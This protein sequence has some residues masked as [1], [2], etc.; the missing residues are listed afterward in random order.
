M[1]S[2]NKEFKAA[3]YKTFDSNEMVSVTTSLNDLSEGN[4]RYVL[5]VDVNDEKNYDKLKP[6]LNEFKAL[7]EKNS[8]SF[9]V[10][11]HDSDP[12][13][14][15]MKDLQQFNFH[16]E[17]TTLKKTIV[18]K[19]DIMTKFIFITDDLNNMG[20]CKWLQSLMKNDYVLT[21]IFA[22][23]NN[24]KGTSVV[25]D[26][27]NL[28]NYSSVVVFFVKD[29]PG[30]MLYANAILSDNKIVVGFAKVGHTKL[31]LYNNHTSS[32][33]LYDSKGIKQVEITARN[34]TQTIECKRDN[35]MESST[36]SYASANSM[37]KLMLE[38]YKDGKTP[39]PNL[40][41]IYSK[42]LET[43]G[44]TFGLSIR[45]IKMYKAL[46]DKPENCD[47]VFIYNLFQLM[48]SL[49]YIDQTGGEISIVMND[50][51][52][53]DVTNLNDIVEA[54]KNARSK[55]TTEELKSND[56]VTTD[57]SVITTDDSVITIV[58]DSS[59]TDAIVGTFCLIPTIF[60]EGGY[61]TYRGIYRVRANEKKIASANM[62]NTFIVLDVSGSMQDYF[63]K[64][65]NMITYTI[66]SLGEN[67]KLTVILFST[68]FHTL[69]DML[70]GSQANKEKMLEA[71]KNSETIPELWGGWTN[72]YDTITECIRLITDYKTKNDDTWSFVLLTDGEPNRG[73]ITT[74]DGA[75]AILKDLVNLPKIVPYLCTY[76]NGIGYAMLRDALPDNKKDHYMHFND[77]EAFNGHISNVIRGRSSIIAT[78]LKVEHGNAK[79]DI[80]PDLLTTSTIEVPFSIDARKCGSYSKVLK[81][82]F[83]TCKIGDK[84]YEMK[85]SYNKTLESEVY[86]NIATK[87]FASN[88][89]MLFERLTIARK[90]FNNSEIEKISKELEELKN[91]YND[92][93]VDNNGVSKQIGVIEKSLITQTEISNDVANVFAELSETSYSMVKFLCGHSPY[94]NGQLIHEACNNIVRAYN[95]CF[96]DKKPDV[97][98][99][100]PDFDAYC[101]K[102]CRDLASPT[103]DV[104]CKDIKDSFGLDTKSEKYHKIKHELSSLI[105]LLRKYYVPLVENCKKLYDKNDKSQTKELQQIMSVYYARIDLIFRELSKTTGSGIK[106]DLDLSWLSRLRMYQREYPLKVN[107]CGSYR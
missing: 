87:L 75:T 13:E 46:K 95:V 54:M 90:R 50:V 74:K 73:K 5:V 60:S 21:Y 105:D 24:C 59:T 36:R 42:F 4:A 100:D 14:E 16:E 15:F 96:E 40:D 70:S 29:C 18:V 62:S 48:Q 106:M 6:S 91:T 98:N 78:L 82:I 69:F 79:Q 61:H 1:S 2:L 43:Y 107:Q 93:G 3:S 7:V 41:A 53:V 20:K 65:K 88:L 102:K 39:G 99:G 67:D 12:D 94:C 76:G 34:Q 28:L 56:I 63:P 84:G 52:V 85:L 81:D 45:L 83:F 47:K 26:G 92:S 25:Y 11:I 27:C 44:N 72:V 58:P 101:Q 8:A 30:I 51:K 104:I 68:Q 22:L 31:T 71:L 66:N 10:H 38:S 35:K 17:V 9:D 103:V 64:M 23:G 89:K 77:I 19:E 97:F 55:E 33:L 86:I 37:I 49:K 80:F 57:D 32:V